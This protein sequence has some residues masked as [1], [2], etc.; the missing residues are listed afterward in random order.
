[1]E[2]RDE[3]N[4]SLTKGEVSLG[5]E[6]VKT[7]H[8]AQNERETSV[9]G[10][11]NVSGGNTTADLKVTE[12]KEDKPTSKCIGV[13]N[14][15]KSSCA[16]PSMTEGSQTHAN[17]DSAPPDKETTLTDRE[18]SAH[19]PQ[20]TFKRGLPVVSIFVMSATTGLAGGII[21]A[22]GTLYFAP[23]FVNIWNNS[24]S[25]SSAHTVH[26][27]VNTTAT[28]LDQC[29]KQNVANNEK[30][31]WL[32]ANIT[33]MRDDMYSNYSNVELKSYI[34]D[35]R[36]EEL[37]NKFLSKEWIF[38]ILLMAILEIAAMAAV[39]KMWTSFTDVLATMRDRPGGVA[40]GDSLNGGPR[41]NN[42]VIQGDESILDKISRCHLDNFVC[43]VAFHPDTI[44]QHHTQ[45]EAVLSQN[46]ATTHI[47]VKKHYVKGHTLL[48]SL[49]PCK[50]YFVFVDFNERHVILED[51]TK[52]LGDLRLTTVQ[53]I[54]KMGGDVVLIY[55]GDIGSRSLPIGTL[56]NSNLTSIK[57]HPELRRLDND[58]RILSVFEKFN[59]SQIDRLVKIVKEHGI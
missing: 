47:G 35:G 33:I 8:L 48:L 4:L 12:V 26:Q 25:I 1:M 29:L 3:N 30:I 20:P 17:P 58:Q 44:K 31:K 27:Q 53:A 18:T 41:H 10:L 52:G 42:D 45:V 49:P 32:E 38:L 39:W 43:V 15:S 36:M 56:Y 46:E 24:N 57:N 2:S 54:R 59:Q 28:T 21:G 51:P 37:K 19:I 6:S 50:I 16:G 14:A 22:L 5:Q 11:K 55:S 13:E 40:R 9:V 23:A 7:G 34:L